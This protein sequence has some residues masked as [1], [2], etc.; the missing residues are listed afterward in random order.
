MIF[1]EV[2]S[3]IIEAEKI[4]VLGSQFLAIDIEDLAFIAPHLH[5][6][7]LVEARVPTLI[8]VRIALLSRRDAGDQDKPQPSAIQVMQEGF[9]DALG[10][11]ELLCHRIPLRLVLAIEGGH[12]AFVILDRVVAHPDV[13]DFAMRGLG[14]L[15]TQLDRVP[16]DIS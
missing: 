12:I 10:F 14:M 3:R 15:G 6:V 5:A 1:D 11:R 2:N 9:S 7:L 8:D 13:I 16:F 4:T